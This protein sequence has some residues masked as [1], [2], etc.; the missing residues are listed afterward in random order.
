MGVALQR[1]RPRLL[2]LADDYTVA[3]AERE[4]ALLLGVSLPAGASLPQWMQEALSVAQAARSANSAGDSIAFLPPDVLARIT[5]MDGLS[6]TYTAVFIERYAQREN[7]GAAAQRY[8]LTARQVE[9]LRLILRG[10]SAHQIAAQLALAE[11]TVA[12]HFKNLLEKTGA[13]NRAEMIA[14]VLGWDGSSEP[15]PAVH[16]A[17]TGQL[18]AVSIT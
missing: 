8:G 5:T 9:V 4:A 12:D 2:L 15:D 3:F 1:T 10:Q 17:P 11:S 13:R 6:T 14:K 16:V 18:R 7:L